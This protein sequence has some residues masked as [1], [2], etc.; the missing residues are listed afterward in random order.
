MGTECGVELDTWTRKT[1]SRNHG[2]N[3]IISSIDSKGLKNGQK[4]APHKL[5]CKFHPDILIRGFLGPYVRNVILSH[6][7]CKSSSLRSIIIYIMFGIKLNS[8]SLG[9]WRLLPGAR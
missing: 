8:F 9:V 5:Q 3:P 1:Y 6:V 2:R 7:Y 4:E